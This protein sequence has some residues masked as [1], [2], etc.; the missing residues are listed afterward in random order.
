MKGNA[1]QIKNLR[2]SNNRKDKHILVVFLWDISVVYLLI[3]LYHDVIATKNSITFQ[4]VPY[5]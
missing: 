2:K 5:S 1:L 3:L 4:A